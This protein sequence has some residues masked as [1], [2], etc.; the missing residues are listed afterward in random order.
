[1]GVIEEEEVEAPVRARPEEA[2]AMSE[3]EADAYP[4]GRTTVVVDPPVDLTVMTPLERLAR[5]V[6]S[7]REKKK[8][9]SQRVVFRSPP[10]QAKRETHK[11]SKDRFQIHR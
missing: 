3:E 1:M 2:S 4:E 11:Q 10:V 9:R 5:A 7:E 8:D 6:S